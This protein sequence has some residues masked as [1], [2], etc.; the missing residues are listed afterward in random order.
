MSLLFFKLLCTNPRGAR[1][2][3]YWDRFNEPILMEQE[4]ESYRLAIV[5]LLADY[6]KIYRIERKNKKYYLHIKE[7]AVSTTTRHREDSLVN[8]FT[9]EISRND[10]LNITNSIEV[11]CYWTMP[12]DIKEDDGWLDGSGWNLEGFK[13]NNNCSNSDY[14]FINRHSPYA[15]NDTSNFIKICEKFMELDSLNIK[16]F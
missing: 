11:N 6:F 16:E 5:V 15:T 7:F 12:V 9:K 3:K 4:N 14:H 2:K 1:Y 13:K 8:S 10:W